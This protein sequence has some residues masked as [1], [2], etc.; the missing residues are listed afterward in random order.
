MG[1]VGR[2]GNA[3]AGGW[4][5]RVVAAVL[6]LA[7]IVCTAPVVPAQTGGFTESLELVPIDCRWRASASA[8]RI[9]EPFSVVL[10]CAVVETASTTVAPDQSRLAPS[11]IDLQPFEVVSGR[12]GQDVRTPGYRHFQYEYDVRYFGELFGEDIP[13]PEL[14]I[15]YRVQSR[16]ESGETIE[17]R[18][19][20]YALP[21]LTVRI[22]SLVQGSATDIREVPPATLAAIDARRFRAS[23]FDIAGIALLILAAVTAVWA[24]AVLT[25]RP[26]AQ[27]TAPRLAPDSAVLLAAARALGDVRRQRH[28][29]G[30][31]SR[32]A[33]RALTALRIAGSLDSGR[34]V[35]QVEANPLGDPEHGRLAVRALWPPR[36]PVWVS[37]SATPV[38]L[39]E[40]IA[41]READG[42]RGTARLKELQRLITALTAAAYAREAGA[43]PEAEALDEAVDTG[44]AIL[45]TLAREHL[46]IVR[47]ARTAGSSAAHLGGR[48]WAR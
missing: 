34:A 1:G 27:Q 3:M 10:T 15:A 17:G 5:P 47:V 36:R 26:R 30:W 20:Q 7:A 39:A 13:V 40:E 12:A 19:L 18:E 22:L 6:A 28:A 9:G 38:T 4:T 31:S 24:A 44:E 35:A 14:T 43:A 46:W 16:L 33:A 11:V 8:V 37:G 2:L 25:R 29:E 32:L 48:V 21:P 23:A 45:R 41:R 42:L